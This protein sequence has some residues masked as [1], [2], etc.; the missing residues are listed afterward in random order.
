MSNEKYK[1]NQVVYFRLGEGKPEGFGKVTGVQGFVVI[2]QPDM[3]VPGYDYTHIYVVDS[4][5]G[6]PPKEVEKEKVE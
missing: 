5:I 1:Q 3:A 4:Q 2:I 6:E